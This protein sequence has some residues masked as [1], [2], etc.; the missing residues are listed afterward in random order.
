MVSNKAFIDAIANAELPIV[1]DS[2][3]IEYYNVPAAFDIETSS[4]YQDENKHACMYVWQFG[5][6]NWVTYGRTWEEFIELLSTVIYVLRLSENRKLIVYVHNLAYE[7]QFMRKWFNWDKIF[8][9]DERKPVYANL[10]FIEFKCSLKLSGKSL[11]NVGKS[12]QKYKVEKLVGNLDYSKIRTSETE[13]TDAEL[14]YMEND[15]RVILAYIQEKIES[16]GDITRI[17]LTNTGYVR[18]YCKKA[19]FSHFKLYKALMNEL[20]LTSDEYSQLKR[21]FMGGFTHA[22]AQY[23]G[24]VLDDVGSF[25]LTSSYPT[26]MLAEKFPMSKSKIIDKIASSEE[27]AQYLR[28]YCCLFDVTFIGL[29]PKIMYEHPLSESKCRNIV[30]QVVDNG[31]IV[32]ALQ[33]TTTATEL[34]FLTYLDFYDFDSFTISNFRI[35][36]KGYLPK[37]FILAILRLYENKTIL[38]DVEGEEVNYQLSKGMINAAYGMTVT[39]IVREIL[40][41]ENHEFS[42]HK[43][44]INEA[45]G[46]YNKNK[47][48]FLFY[49]WGVWVTAYARRN[50]FSGIKA[51]GNDYIYSDTDSLKLLNAEKHLDYINWYNNAIT[52]KLHKMAGFYKIE[53]DRL[54]PKNKYGKEKPL[55]VWEFE[56]IFDEFKTLG[57]KRYLTR[58]GNEYKLTVAGVNKFSAI[59]YMEHIGNPFDMF[60]ANLII[61]EQYSGR[62]V[63]SYSDEECHDYVTDYLGKRS[64]YHERSFIHMEGTSFTL[65]IS[66]EYKSFIEYIQGVKDISW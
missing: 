39:D 25:D 15:I 38:K 62:K 6:L 49:P 35:Y 55:G 12:L 3:N 14:A 57:A 66:P 7:F 27:L 8:F 33:L 19:C 30:G 51:I 54:A 20:T 26:V 63:L 29:V 28:K 45:I 16:D 46:I 50:L 42:S 56:G 60:K 1:R 40:E 21:A 64:E 34:D 52:N 5:I 18:R 37:D 11:E 41:Y 13:L 36:E 48:R 32:T 22:S 59:E 23:A 44:D 31:R 65:D 9:L 47:N 17:P 61:P 4:F 24:K 58:K 43:P 10:K 2:K 53:I